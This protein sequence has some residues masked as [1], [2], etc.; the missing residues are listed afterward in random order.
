MFKPGKSTSLFKDMPK[1]PKGANWAGFNKPGFRHIYVVPALGGTARQVTSGDYH[2]GGVINWSKDSKNIIIDGDRHDDWQDRPIESD[3]YQVNVNTGNITTLVK[4]DG[5]DNRPLISPNGKKIAY[6]SFEDK[7]LSSQ[8]TQLY[9]MDSNGKNAKNLTP[10]LDRSVS[11]C[12]GLKMVK[13]YIFL[14]MI[15]VKAMW[16][17]LT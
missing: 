7:K 5:P 15:M 2:H 16:V 17:T 14:M 12:I 11:M 8:N 9:V 1:K 4:R 10:D 3:I 13:V 6:L